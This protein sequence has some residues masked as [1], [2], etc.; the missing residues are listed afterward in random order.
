MEKDCYTPSDIT[1]LLS[2]VG[3]VRGVVLF[4]MSTDMALKLISTMLG[5][6][7]QEFDDLAQ[8]GIAEMGNVITGVAAT[9]LAEAGY[10]CSI[11]VPTL[12]VGRGTMLSTL[13]FT[14]LVV[15]LKTSFGNMSIHIALR[16]DP[17]HDQHGQMGRAVVPANGTSAERVTL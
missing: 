11:S 14:R 8:S 9:H 10:R 17:R 7:M 2:V 15:P 12:I 6:T 1:V 3:D 5:Q 4:S 13:D 16:E